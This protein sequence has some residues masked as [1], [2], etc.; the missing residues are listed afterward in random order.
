MNKRPAVFVATQ[1]AAVALNRR[2]G[3]FVFASH[4][5]QPV[6]RHQALSQTFR[7]QD[8]TCGFPQWLPALLTVALLSM[9]A[10]PAYPQIGG[11]FGGGFG[12]GQGGQ[13]G[14]GQGGGGGG[15]FPGG[16]AINADVVISSPAAQRINPALE[17]KRLK[18]VASTSLSNDITRVSELR[19]V[20]LVRLEKELQK[21]IDA[22]EQ[23]SPELRYL[24]GITQIQYLFVMPETGDLVIA[25]P[26]E[27]FAPQQDG[28]V[29][30]VETGRPVLVLDD[31]LALLRLSNINQTLG[32]SF[33]PD[34]NRLAAATA[35]NNANNSP[36]SLAVAKQRFYQMASIL[37]NWDV[38]VFGLPDSCHAAVLTVEADYQLKRLA[39]GID[40]PKIRTFRSH[41]DMA[42]PGEN[43]MRRWWIA[44][45][46]DVIERSADGH[47]FHLGGPSLQ[48]MSQEELVDA[49][50]NREDAAF[51]EISA[52]KYTQMFNKNLEALVKQIPCFAEV[53]NL[54]DL[55]VVTALIRR[56]NM[57]LLV[58]WT[59]G[60]MFDEEKLPIQKYNVPTEVPSLVNVKSA[61]RSLLIGLIG[62]GVTIYPANIISR[63]DELAQ[64]KIPSVTAPADDE[65]SWWW[66]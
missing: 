24:A 30:G 58:N 59:P 10:V 2:S 20:S 1:P 19:K 61:G 23:I 54:F 31:L 27:G 9:C 32:C 33:D 18:E 5:R 26:A 62:G 66:D 22:G 56:D 51:T 6:L 63:T 64:D 46:Y 29:V 25:G 38:T 47:A 43:T 36:A 65:G 17:Q 34:K 50:G 14:G 40:K 12:G 16:I 55:A 37:G 35:W 21:Q 13:G 44:P 15:G 28:R 45:R 57:D 4:A 11:N 52:E 48:L 39:L 49:Q 42:R 8:R 60:I 53:Q 41:L 3:I 7:R